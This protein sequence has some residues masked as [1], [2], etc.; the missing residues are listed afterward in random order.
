MYWSCVFLTDETL[1]IVTADHSHS[2]VIYG[3]TKRGTPIFGFS[4]HIPKDGLPVLTLAY[5]N[6]PG[7]LKPNE[8]RANLTGVDYNAT[9]FR[10]Q[11]LI[12]TSS[13]DHAGEDV[14]MLKTILLVAEG[15]VIT[16]LY[17]LSRRRSEY[18]L[19]ITSPEAINCFSIN[20]QVFT[21]NN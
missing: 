5:A 7:G 2:F 17:L 19:V 6:G 15:E 9:D 18:R 14:G 3:R 16:S 12:L 11:A 8:S 21:N 4:G 1:L 20:F 10:Q 13:E